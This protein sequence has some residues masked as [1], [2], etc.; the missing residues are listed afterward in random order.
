MAY[1]VSLETGIGNYQDII[2]A[3]KTGAN[4]IFNTLVVVNIGI[5]SITS[6]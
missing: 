2:I 1:N 3:H 6:V 5:P 4:T